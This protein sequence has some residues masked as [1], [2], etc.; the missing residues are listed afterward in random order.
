MIGQNQRFAKA[1][2]EA[3][4]III[5]ENFLYKDYTQPCEKVDDEQKMMIAFL[6][7]KEYEQKLDKLAHPDKEQSVTLEKDMQLSLVEYINKYIYELNDSQKQQIC[8][9]IALKIPEKKIKE[10][11]NMTYEDMVKI[12]GRSG[13]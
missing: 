12:T 11:F 9:A 13:N 10:M 8:E 1:H 5:D 3:K 6:K 4:K 2:A 7:E